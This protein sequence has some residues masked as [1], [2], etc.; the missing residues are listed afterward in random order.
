MLNYLHSNQWMNEKAWLKMALEELFKTL[1]GKQG[2]IVQHNPW[3]RQQKTL[4]DDHW[5]V[6]HTEKGGSDELVIDAKGRYPAVIKPWM[7]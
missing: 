5:L 4:G 2:S 6:S 3:S 1:I 7:I